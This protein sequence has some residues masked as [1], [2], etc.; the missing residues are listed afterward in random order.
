MLY[1]KLFKLKN[2]ITSLSLSFQYCKKFDLFNK[3]V[4]M[5]VFINKFKSFLIK[6]DQ[7]SLNIDLTVKL[8]KIPSFARKCSNLT[9]KIQK[10]ETNEII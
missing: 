3:E 10:F 7:I 1:R 8:F 6:F 4:E 9:E 5:P 2:A